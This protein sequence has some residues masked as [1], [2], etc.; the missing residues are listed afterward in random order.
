MTAPVNA[1]AST[2]VHNGPPRAHSDGGAAR[3]SVGG[4]RPYRPAWTA[5]LRRRLLEA[6][7]GDLVRDVALRTGF[8]VETTRRYFVARVPSVVFLRAVCEAYGVSADWLLLGR[9]TASGR[10][11]SESHPHAPSLEGLLADV[12]R[13]LDAVN[14]SLRATATHLPP[15]TPKTP[16]LAAHEPPAAAMKRR[17]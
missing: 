7:R 4:Q 5:D 12:G 1:A 16:T 14:L 11:G 3:V 2:H 10:S 15:M 9:G 8:C 17:A 13:R 6:T